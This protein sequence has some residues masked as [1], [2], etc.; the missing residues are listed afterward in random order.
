MRSRIMVYA[1]TSAC[2]VTC[3]A[4]VS[5]QAEMPIA[6]DISIEIW[7]CDTTIASVQPEEE[8][9]QPVKP[10]EITYTEMNL[11]FNLMKSTNEDI[12]QEWQRKAAAAVQNSRDWAVILYSH[13]MLDSPQKQWTAWWTSIH[14]WTEF[15]ESSEWLEVLEELYMDYAYD[16][17]VETWKSKR[18]P[19]LA[20]EETEQ[21]PVKPEP[22]KET[23]TEIVMR[24]NLTP[25]TSADDYAKWLNS[26]NVKAKDARGCDGTIS[27]ENILRARQFQWTSWW[28]GIKDWIE[29]VQEKEWDEIIESLSSSQNE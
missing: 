2:I 19:F 21:H 26:A 8:T 12:F 23:N 9:D 11:T 1:M 7:K 22:F 10:E 13:N 6:T 5:C 3:L 18:K 15:A 29:F 20:P 27:S 17:R 25:G 28:N 16:V 4:L 14:G 24:F